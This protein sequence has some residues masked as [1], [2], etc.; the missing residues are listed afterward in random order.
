MTNYNNHDRSK[1]GYD[2]Y[3]GGRSPSEPYYHSGSDS[4]EHVRMKLQEI[5][6][7]FQRA[8]EVKYQKLHRSVERAA[9]ANERLK[10][11]QLLRDQMREQL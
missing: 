7:K 2:R 11:K 1:S 9:Q 8:E 10:V 4:E 6:T 3:R 5:E